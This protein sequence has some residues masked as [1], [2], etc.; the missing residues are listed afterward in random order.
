[1]HM[2]ASKEKER[3]NY[4]NKKKNKNKNKIIYIYIYIYIY[5]DVVMLEN[6][7]CMIF[8]KLYLKLSWDHMKYHVKSFI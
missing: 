3:N 2:L 4:K 5:N 7:V 1:M 6:D 8:K